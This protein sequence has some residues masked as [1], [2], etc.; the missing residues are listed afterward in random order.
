MLFSF[1]NRA[2]AAGW[3]I[4]TRRAEIAFDRLRAGEYTLSMFGDNYF[5]E[6]Q[7]QP[8][9]PSRRIAIGEGGCVSELFFAPKSV[10]P[11]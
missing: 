1:S 3:P 4:P 6:R 2:N 5:E 9:A 7:P 11:K 10:A 8:L